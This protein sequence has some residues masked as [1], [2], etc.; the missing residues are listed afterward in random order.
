MSMSELWREVQAG[1][2]IAIGEW[3]RRLLLPTTV[4]V[5]FF[6]ALPIS[7]IQKR[8]GKAG[9]LILGVTLVFAYFNIQLLM[10]QKVS[11]GIF[12]GWSMWLDQGALFALG[13]YLWRRAE[14]DRLPKLLVQLGEQFALLNQWI[15]RK[16]AKRAG[17]S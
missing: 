15:T 8:S 1:K 17:S 6:F 7:L 16:I 14:A 2:A 9:V 12:P 11:N 13:F 10:H 4:L 3:S 5:F